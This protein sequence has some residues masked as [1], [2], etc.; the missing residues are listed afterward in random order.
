MIA[1]ITI[2]LLFVVLQAVWH[3]YIIEKR[4]QSPNHY[5]HFCI[6]LS[7]ASVLCSYRN[8]LFD[9]YWFID[10]IFYGVMFSVCFDMLL[11]KLRRKKI[12]YVGTTSVLDKLF[13]KSPNHYWGIR[14]VLLFMFSILFFS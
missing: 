14:A 2:W 1:L 8:Y 9:L 6:R 4:K 11:N 12:F 5:L 10:L 13:S 3:W 7:V